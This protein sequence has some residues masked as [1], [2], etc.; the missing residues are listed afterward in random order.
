MAFVYPP[1]P[2]C[3]WPQTKTVKN[4]VQKRQRLRATFLECSAE[5]KLL[6]AYFP[7]TSE[8]K[9]HRREM[10]SE[11]LVELILTSHQG[12]SE[13]M[14]GSCFMSL[15]RVSTSFGKCRGNLQ[16]LFKLKCY[17]LVKTLEP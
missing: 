1:S 4:R 12:E 2:I 6:D 3:H 5:L 13:A 9:K 17:Y 10:I 16:Q 8:E 7:A 11:H 14:A 15:S